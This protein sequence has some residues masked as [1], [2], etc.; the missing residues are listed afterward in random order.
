MTNMFAYCTKLKTIYTSVLFTTDLVESFNNMFKS[1]T[2]IV[3]GNGI[4]YNSSY[5]DKTYARIDIDLLS[6]Y[7]TQKQLLNFSNY[8]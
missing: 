5:L 4:T 3:G 6:G 2:L 8:F 1:F 7:F